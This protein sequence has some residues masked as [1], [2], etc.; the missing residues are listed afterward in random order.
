MVGVLEKIH[1]KIT[2]ALTMT[3]VLTME[4]YITL[5]ITD[6]DS[7]VEGQIWYDA[8]ENKLK[9]YNGAAVETITSA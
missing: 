7:A 4:N 5:H 1:K 9:F 2:E 3:E 6:T 8:S